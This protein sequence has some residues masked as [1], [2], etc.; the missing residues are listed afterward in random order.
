MFYSKLL[1]TVNGLVIAIAYFAA[2]AWGGNEHWAIALISMAALSALTI[3]IIA[4]AGHQFAKIKWEWCYLPDSFP[5]LCVAWN[6]HPQSRSCI[7]GS[8]VSGQRGKLFHDGLFSTLPFLRRHPVS[9][10]QRFSNPATGKSAC[11]LHPRLGHV[12]GGLWA[13]PVPG[14][15]RLYLAI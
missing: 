1:V 2:L 11:G 10:C 6:Y 5:G 15:L 14:R 4:E 9:H 3:R 7:K 8:M 12:S 13:D